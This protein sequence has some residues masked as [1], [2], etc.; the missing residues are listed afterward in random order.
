[1]ILTKANLA[2]LYSLAV[3]AATT[4]GEMISKVSVNDLTITFKDPNSKIPSSV[5]TEIDIKSQEIILDTLKPTLDE[6]DLG[7]LTEEAIDDHSRF[8]KDFFWAIDPL[9]GT[10]PFTQ[11]REGYSVS[12][13]LV[14]K[15]G[16]PIIGVV[17][18][19]LTGNCYSA[20]KNGGA[21]RNTKKFCLQDTPLPS[22]NKNLPLTLFFDRS[23]LSSPNYDACIEQLSHFSNKHYN[24]ELVINKHKGAVLNAIGLLEKTPSLY[25]KFPR[26]GRRGGS[27][28]DYAAT[29][30][31][32]K[33]AG[34]YVSD[35]FSNPLD[36]NR[37][38]STYLN[39]SGV[40]YASC[41]A[42][43]DFALAL[44]SNPMV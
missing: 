19:P 8:K 20:Q 12:I 34:A 21:K 22:T 4:S 33:E 3:K 39:A 28:W 15:D 18:D 2:K 35:I 26:K 16:T 32:C 44:Y 9:D 7:M 41:K 1:M 38:D 23:F 36:L 30:C 27:I 42:L 29:A 10:F 31:I 13:A 40:V 43:Y 24:G 5:L 6:F 17:Y 11:G 37:K 25:F 14:S